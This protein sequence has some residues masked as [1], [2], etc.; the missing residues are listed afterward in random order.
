MAFKPKLYIKDESYDPIFKTVET[1]FFFKSRVL[2]AMLMSMGVIILGSQVAI[3]LVFFKTQ[4]KIAKPVTSTV[5]GVASGFTDFQ[6]N[7]LKTKGG[8]SSTTATQEYFTLSIPKLKIENAVVEENSKNLNPDESLGHYLGSKLPGE[9]GNSFIYGHSVLPWFYNPKN[10]KTIFSTL[11]SLVAGDKV[12]LNYNNKK[13]T[14]KVESKEILDPN[15]VNPLAEFK[16]AYLNESTVTLM[17]C[18]PAGTRSKR[19]LVK[20]VL[21]DD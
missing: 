14:Y 15:K 16:P 19:L 20:A 7:E 1:R 12:Q 5:L 10:Y 21:S 11:D 17:T 6:F 8:G 9:I 18:W 4:T 13:L 3:P 2:P